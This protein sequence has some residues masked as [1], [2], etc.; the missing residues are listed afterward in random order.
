[1]AS[2]NQRNGGASE[3]LERRLSRPA[4]INCF[5]ARVGMA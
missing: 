1:M 4:L 2:G 5:A 3:P